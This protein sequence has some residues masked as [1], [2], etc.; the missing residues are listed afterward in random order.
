MT[1]RLAHAK[2]NLA[3]V[4]GPVR[5]GGKHEVATILQ[6][7]ALAD[8]IE[9]SVGTRLRVE[10]FDSD[11]IVTRALRMLAAEAGIDPSWRVRI[12]KEIPVAAGLG[13]GS[14]DAAAALLL[15][16]QSLGSPFTFERLA[17]IATE[18]GAD[19]PFFLHEGPQ[20]GTGDGSR[21]AALELPDAFTVVLVVPDDVQ[22]ESTASVYAA[23]DER[24]GAVGFHE[25]RAALG[26]TL[27]VIRETEDLAG[28]PPNDLATSPVAELLC[29]AGA[30]RADVSGAGPCVYGVFA[31]PALASAA[32]TD[33]RRFGRT[34]VTTPVR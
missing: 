20:L 16:N 30:I 5:E 17:A 10:G 12:D 15:A 26:A 25:R 34:W 32:G 7:V 18:I 3:L 21:L 22:K 23:F 28:L 1:T 14:S 6:R 9:L 33:L 29:D 13:G 31:D 19:V 4:V 24:G 11:T 8:T 2:I 27:A